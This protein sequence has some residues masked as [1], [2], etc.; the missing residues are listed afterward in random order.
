[1]P[2]ISVN[3]LFADKGDQLGLTW[4]AGKGGGNKLLTSDTVQKLTLALIGY[5]NFVHPNRVQVLGCAEMDY[6]RSLTPEALAQSVNNLFSTELAAIIVA[7]GESVPP[8]LK[9]AADRT[10]TPL[11][12]SLEQ[13]PDMMNVL[14]HYLAQVLA[15]TTVRH[16]VFMEVQGMG[17]LITGDSAVGKSE[18]A[19]EL[20]TRGHRLVADDVVEFYQVSPDTLEG[21]CPAMLQDFLE[22]RGLGVLNIRALFGEAAVKLK[23]NIKLI[24]HL[25]KQTAQTMSMNRLQINTY[26][27]QILDAT[28][29]EV[30]IPVAAGRNIAVLVEVAVRNHI[31][32]LRGINSTQQFIE[33]HD[34]MMAEDKPST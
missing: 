12:T 5:L 17:V 1:M 32:Q 3:Q 21:R 11:F 25:E 18:L 31:L 10:L 8:L 34:R 4:V 23:K 33:R 14:R 29:P 24:V 2:Q 19:L 30:R 6:L 20:I 9:E 15:E 28:I 22:V 27:Q 16:G 7:N 13:S 26:S